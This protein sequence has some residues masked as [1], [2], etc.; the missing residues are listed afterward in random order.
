MLTKA[1]AKIGRVLSTLLV[2]VVVLLAILLVGV[3]VVGL[4]PYTVLSGSMEP[5]FHVGSLIYVKDV[6]PANIAV[7]DAITLV[8]NEDLV[9]A[10]HQVYEID[11]ENK[12]FY[13]QGINN[14]DENGNIIHDGNYVHFNNLIGK[15]VFTIPYLGY[16]STYLTQPPGLYIGISVA[17]I[18]VLLLLMPDMLKKAAQA[19]QK[20]EALMKADNPNQGRS[21]KAAK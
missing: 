18:L 5:Q 3:R 10:T 15:P 21:Q 6:D 7:G 11:A 8:M 2:C 4:K 20:K 17:L 16:V 13:T 12:R 14:K 19:D 1:I 9:V